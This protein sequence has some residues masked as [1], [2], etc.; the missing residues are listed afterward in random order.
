MSNLDEEAFNGL[1]PSAKF[2]WNEH[3]IRSG[4]WQSVSRAFAEYELRS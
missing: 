3:D 4:A 2:M 1:R